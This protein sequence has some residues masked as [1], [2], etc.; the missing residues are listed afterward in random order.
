VN[1][2]IFE[3]RR[4]QL[5]HAVPGR[6]AEMADDPSVVSVPKTKSIPNVP[7]GRLVRAL[8]ELHDQIHTP[9][10]L[11]IWDAPR[12]SMVETAVKAQCVAHELMLRG[13]EVDCPHCRPKH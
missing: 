6:G 1:S 7:T 3:H 8:A 12:R 10:G 13:V 9:E 5:A 11:A 2:G 4:N